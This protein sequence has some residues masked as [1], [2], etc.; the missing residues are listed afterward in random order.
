MYR[1]EILDKSLASLSNE[2]Q[3]ILR[4]YGIRNL[5]DVAFWMCDDVDNVRKFENEVI[6][7]FPEK[8]LIKL[9]KLLLKNNCYSRIRHAEHL[10]SVIK[11][12]ISVTAGTFRPA[13]YLQSVT[14]EYT[15]DRIQGKIHL[16]HVNYEGKIIKNINIHVP[17]SEMLSFFYIVDE[18]FY[19]GISLDTSCIFD[20]TKYKVSVKYADNSIIDAEGCST[21]MSVNVDQIIEDMKRIVTMSINKYYCVRT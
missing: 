21:G 7:D 18:M 1:D 4:E 15:I 2:A 5:Y 20:S 16:K 8:D 14:E 17:D 9:R 6:S 3:K 10:K 11:L 13:G 19:K 12:Q